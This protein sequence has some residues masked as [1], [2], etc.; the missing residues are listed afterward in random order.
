MHSLHKLPVKN[1][2]FSFTT[3]HNKMLDKRLFWPGSS[4]QNYK[5]NLSLPIKRLLVESKLSVMLITNWMYLTFLQPL[6]HARLWLYLK[7]TGR[8]KKRTTR[9]KNLWLNLPLGW[10]II[11]MN[12]TVGGLLGYSS[13]NSNCNLNVP[14]G[15]YTKFVS[16]TSY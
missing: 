3:A 16:L 15:T 14:V 13:V 5:K 6:R 7:L 4:R 1:K 10:N 2:V 12:L 9:G 8:K 11:D